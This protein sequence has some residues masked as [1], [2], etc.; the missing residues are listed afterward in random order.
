MSDSEEDSSVDSSVFGSSYVI[1]VDSSDPMS[2]SFGGASRISEASDDTEATN[3]TNVTAGTD[4]SSIR[5]APEL[6]APELG[7]MEWERAMTPPRRVRVSPNMETPGGMPRPR[8]M[9]CRFSQFSQ[10]LSQSLIEE[11]P[12]TNFW[13]FGTSCLRSRCVN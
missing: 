3:V 5:N 7:E 1:S 9:E 10:R 13:C 11:S 6:D 8:R 4:T 12:A 2:G